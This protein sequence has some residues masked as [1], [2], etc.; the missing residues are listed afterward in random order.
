MMRIG[1]GLVGLKIE[2]MHA[3]AARSKIQRGPVMPAERTTQRAG[4]FWGHFG[5]ALRGLW[6]HFVH[7]GF[8]F[9]I[10]GLLYN[11]FRPFSKNIH[12]SNRF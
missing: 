5:V 11:H 6:G 1:A 10:S 12:F 4:C 7:F 3:T 2:N 9:V 8:T